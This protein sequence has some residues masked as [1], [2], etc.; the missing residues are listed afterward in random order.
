MAGKLYIAGLDQSS[1][2]S[3]LTP[4]SSKPVT[5]QTFHDVTEDR[6]SDE[7][8]RRRKPGMLE[9]PFALETNTAP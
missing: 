9:V 1:E 8:Q 5:H 2:G 3:Q 7:G 4:Q 6:N